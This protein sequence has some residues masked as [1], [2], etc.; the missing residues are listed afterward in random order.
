MQSDFADLI[1]NASINRQK[2]HSRLTY[3]R[4]NRK[5]QTRHTY[6]ECT[7]DL[8]VLLYQRAAGNNVAVEKSSTLRFVAIK[9]HKYSNILSYLQAAVTNYMK[10]NHTKIMFYILFLFIQLLN[11]D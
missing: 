10:Q 5:D 7:A 1:E 2:L 8:T 6:F 9:D 3:Y 4:I 11:T